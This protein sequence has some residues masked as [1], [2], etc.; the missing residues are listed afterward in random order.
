MNIDGRSFMSILIQ[1]QAHYVIR[2]NEVICETK[3]SYSNQIST[4]HE[5][6]GKPSVSFEIVSEG[7]MENHRCQVCRDA[8]WYG[9]SA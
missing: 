6:K 8:V 3:L 1:A 9:I 5:I 4:Y 2:L 7:F